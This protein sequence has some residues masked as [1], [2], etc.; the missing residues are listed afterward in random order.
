MPWS[1]AWRTAVVAAGVLGLAAPAP[2]EAVEYRLLV[3]NV[4]ETGFTAYLGARAA[5]GA[6]ESTVPRLEA[7]LDTG[8]FPSGVMLH[9]WLLEPGAGRLARSFQA[10]EPRL[11]TGAAPAAPGQWL[12]VR[13][14]GQPGER[15]VWAIVPSGQAYQEAYHVALGAGEPLRHFIPYSG[16]FPGRP[17]AAYSVPRPLILDGRQD[18][19]LWSHRLGGATDLSR[20][21]AAVVG[22]SE[23]PLR[24][25]H[26]YL[27]VQHPA[28]PR[29]FKAV[30][31]WRPRPTQDFRIQSPGVER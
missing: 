18:S 12:E 22:R 23:D 27:V 5:R 25:D 13:W 28:E 4:Q 26:V 9:G 21:V 19:D 15:S 30:V 24:A 20:G 17:A 1:I 29:T 2:A 3:A 31:G 7:S 16:A 8:R 11:V 14:D 10:A 6:G